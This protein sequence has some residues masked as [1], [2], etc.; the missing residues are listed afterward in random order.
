[1]KSIKT[2]TL[3]LLVRHFGLPWVTRR[4]VHDIR[5]RSGFLRWVA[6]I[7]RWRDVSFESLL[8][9]PGLAE[10]KAYYTKR[11]E[12]GPVFFFT[13][14]SDHLGQ[15]IFRRWDRKRSPVKAAEDILAGRFLCYS[16]VLTETGYPPDWHAS[17]FGNYRIA[18]DK[19]WSEID[20]FE[21]VDI[22][23]IWELNRFA[24]AYTL[25]RAYWRTGDER[26]SEAFWTLL[27]SWY[28]ANQP[29]RG[30]NWKCGQEI[31]FRLMA[32]CFALY[33]FWEAKS[34]TPER[35]T[36][37]AQM[38]A[39][40]G[41]RIEANISY[42][43]QQK[44]NHGIS[45]AVGLWTIGLLFPEFK[46]S[47]R[48]KK[49]GRELLEEQVRELVYEDG[50]FSQHSANY[51]R[52]LLHDLIWALRLGQL[53]GENLGS[54]TQAGFKRAVD[55]LCDIQVGA[56]GE[57]PN[58]GQN[59]GALILPLCNCE[60]RDFRPVLQAGRFLLDGIRRYREGPWDEDLF[61]LFGKE[62]LSTPI[63]PAPANE[64]RAELGGYYG[65]HSND[66]FLFIRAPRFKHR[67][68]Q[69]D[70]LHLD[71]W[72]K[73]LNIAI[74]PGTYSYNSPEP[75][76]NP[77]SQTSFHN[78]ITVDGLDQMERVGKF[79]W[80]PWVR[81]RICES[82][83]EKKWK[84]SEFE[85]DGYLRLQPPVAIRRSILLMTEDTFLVLDRI[86]STNPHKYRLQWLIADLP[87]I[88]DSE[89]AV[90]ELSILGLSYSVSLG[91]SEP[92]SVTSLVRADKNSPRGWYAPGYYS[93][94]PAL[95]I[96]MTG[97]ATG[98]LF[99]S[100]FGP[101]ENRRIKLVG[102]DL[103]AEIG[104][105]SVQLGLNLKAGVPLVREIEN[106]V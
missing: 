39:V 24:F 30:V 101:A 106:S 68:S 62:V 23:H 41:E 71:V 85:H 34:T 65:V 90:L 51:H 77:F 91:S 86:Q 6:P 48:W 20:D 47:Q 1:L 52:V 78:T 4:V 99:W 44:N 93:K 32:W 36:R 87:F 14:K 38:I 105:V 33:A 66:T 22:K 5:R 19:H 97:K 81:G 98:M 61:W 57:V 18:W 73:G 58:F 11:S 60:F 74:D 45:E 46:N 67:P 8:L 43:L 21:K 103:V 16:L 92:S 28:S 17:P 12:E 2:K 37:L 96:D 63:A 69:A 10:P 83:I 55:F 15:R 64:V 94:V 59:D 27:E 49:K 88:W 79:I 26:F 56:N 84:I 3:A 100:V 50:A 72:W 13:P 104:K 40:S 31:T 80:L 9:E 54:E 95:S 102:E 89:K 42:A 35:V 29:N 25:V 53:N 82:R 76:D 70:L 75:W 7:T